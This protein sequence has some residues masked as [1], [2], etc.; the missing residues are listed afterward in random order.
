MKKKPIKK[1]VI[2]VLG[3]KFIT[4]TWIPNKPGERFND[5]FQKMFEEECK[6]REELKQYKANKEKNG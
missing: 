2:K 4:L 1:L 6:Y 3:K 5:L